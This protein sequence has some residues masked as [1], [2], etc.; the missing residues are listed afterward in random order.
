[1]ELQF[2]VYGHMFL[3]WN[4]SAWARIGGRTQAVQDGHAGTTDYTAGKNTTTSLLPTTHKSQCLRNLHWKDTQERLHG[5]EGLWWGRSSGRGCMCTCT[6]S[7][8]LLGGDSGVPLAFR[9]P[10]RHRLEAAGADG[11]AS[12]QGAHV[13]LGCRT[14]KSSGCHC[15]YHLQHTGSKSSLRHVMREAT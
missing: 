6:P 4:F 12:L 9:P 3:V 8:T 10:V 2:M 5:G 7:L 14:D 11:V 15:R 1:M 13:V